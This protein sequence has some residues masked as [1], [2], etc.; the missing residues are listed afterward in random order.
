MSFEAAESL[1]LD[2]FSVT[3]IDPVSATRKFAP[4]SPASASTK[5]DCSFSRLWSTSCLLSVGSLKSILS[6]FLSNSLTAE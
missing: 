2:S 1:R 6:S 5:N 4:V 3:A